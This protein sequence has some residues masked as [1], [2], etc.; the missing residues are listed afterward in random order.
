M[1]RE[2]TEAR[3]QTSSHL[4]PPTQAVVSMLMSSPGLR[5]PI[6][7]Q[8]YGFQLW[9]LADV[10]PT[11]CSIWRTRELVSPFGSFGEFC[12][13]LITSLHQVHWCFP[14]GEITAQCGC[15]LYMRVACS[16]S[17]PSLESSPSF[18]FKVR[19]QIG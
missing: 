2:G 9:L 5:A 11:H 6:N 13:I 16:A 19:A 10:C 4:C 15:Y 8:P 7:S 3:P 1:V 14:R 17:S 18:T 12:Q